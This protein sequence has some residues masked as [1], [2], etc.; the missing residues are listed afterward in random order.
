MGEAAKR[1]L[2]GA[3]RVKGSADKYDE[4]PHATSYEAVEEP[5]AVWEYDYGE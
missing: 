5:P 2:A 1:E 3:S 4:P